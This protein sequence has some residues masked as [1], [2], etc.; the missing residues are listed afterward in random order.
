M[1]KDVVSQS[2]RQ[3]LYL[4]IDVHKDSWNVSF[5]LPNYSL[6][7][8]TMPPS[9][10]SLRAHLDRNYPSMEYRSVYEAGF[11]GFSTH[12]SL[13]SVGIENIVVHAADVPTSDKDK[14][15]KSDAV[16][17]KKLGHALSAGLL[18]PL[19]IPPV[20]CEGLRSLDRL[21]DQLMKRRTQTKNY[22]RTLLFRCGVVVPDRLDPEDPRP[23]NMGNWSREFVA[24]LEAVELPS[25]GERLSLDLYL[26]ELRSHNER[27][28]QQRQAIK[29]LLDS[30]PAAGKIIGLLQSITGIGPLT[31][32]VLYCELYDIDRFNSFDQLCSYVGV[33]PLSRSSG[34][35]SSQDRLTRRC[36]RRL[37]TRL[38]ESAWVAVKHDPTMTAKFPVERAGKKSTIQRKKAIIKIAR[39]L[40]LRVWTV[41]RRGAAWVPT[42][43]GEEQTAAGSTEGRQTASG[44]RARLRKV[45][46][47]PQ[48]EQPTA[49]KHEGSLRP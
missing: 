30:D 44:N 27:L 15:G 32:R 13:E 24:W 36:N 35:T 29:G 9:A 38:V 19:S 42:R 11:T 47:Q 22:I 34:T 20:A 12:R 14:Q 37:R 18:T 10:A 2:D 45:E 39:Q 17:S 21:Y 6:K 8:H 41:W 33:V 28:K 48:P 5:R 7:S 25:A 49:E 26:E 43:P 1:H 16:D 46:R 31:A 4:G 3:V 40:L 23:G